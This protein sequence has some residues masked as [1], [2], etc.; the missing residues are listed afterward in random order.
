MGSELVGDNAEGAVRLR[1]EVVDTVALGAERSEA[2]GTESS[3]GGLHSAGSSSADVAGRRRAAAYC[4]DLA[5]S[6]RAMPGVRRVW[7]APRSYFLFIGL[8]AKP[9]RACDTGSSSAF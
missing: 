2:R 1:D 5:A 7:H 8:R 4:L 3:S 6:R 9:G